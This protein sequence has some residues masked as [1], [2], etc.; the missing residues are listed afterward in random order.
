MRV[1]GDLNFSAASS[2]KNIISMQFK[3]AVAK[4][5]HIN[6]LVFDLTAMVTRPSFRV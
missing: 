5:A 4:N 2:L 3:E 1:E 6:S